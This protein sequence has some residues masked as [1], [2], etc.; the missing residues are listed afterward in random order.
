M[1]SMFIKCQKYV[2]YAQ[3]GPIKTSINASRTINNAPSGNCSLTILMT[4]GRF[5]PLPLY[6]TTHLYSPACVVALTFFK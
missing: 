4:K 1:A 6:T 3:K 5:L 2:I